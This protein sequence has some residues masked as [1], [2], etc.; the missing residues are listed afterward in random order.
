[1][2]DVDSAP[3]TEPQPTDFDWFEAERQAL[4]GEREGQA[5]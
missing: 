3:N 1:L 2:F 4:A 5:F